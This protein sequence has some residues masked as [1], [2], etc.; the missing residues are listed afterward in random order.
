M[1]FLDE[2]EESGHRGVSFFKFSEV[3]DEFAAD[4]DGGAREPLRVGEADD[5]AT[6]GQVSG[7]PLQNQDG[8]FAFPWVAISP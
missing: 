3:D 8:G 4:F 6:A 2:P 1:S 7:G 5:F